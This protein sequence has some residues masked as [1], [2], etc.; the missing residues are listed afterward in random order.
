MGTV[1]IIE[2]DAKLAGLLSAYLSKYEYHVV[3][4]DDFNNVLE[5]F[6]KSAADLVCWMLF[7]QNMMD[8]IGVVR[9]ANLRFV[10]FCSSPQ[11]TAGWIR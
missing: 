6:K 9:Y 7:C 11:E 10:Q 4:A 2:D 5:E 1:F 3:I 8:F